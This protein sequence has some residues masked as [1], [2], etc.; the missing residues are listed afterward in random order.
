VA[1]LVAEVGADGAVLVSVT[2]SAHRAAVVELTS[3]AA[4][5][6][7][8]EPQYPADIP[9][10]T[11]DNPRLPDGEQAARMPYAAP[12]PT[13]PHHPVVRRALRRRC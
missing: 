2:L 6:E 7:N 1:K 9:A 12:N 11:T 13:G 4:H 10:W 5:L 8:E 3:L